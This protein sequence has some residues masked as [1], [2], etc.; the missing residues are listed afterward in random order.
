MYDCMYIHVHV[1]V[2]NS[3]CSSEI[4]SANGEKSVFK[5]VKLEKLRVLIRPLLSC[6]PSLVLFGKWVL[7]QLLLQCGCGID[8]NY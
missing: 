8:T 3:K 4:R 2:Y 7:K 6:N 1:H 5:V